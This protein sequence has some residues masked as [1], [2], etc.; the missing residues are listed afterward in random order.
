MLI[1]LTT[2]LVG[3]GLQ[4]PLVQATLGVTIVVLV[5]VYGREQHVRELI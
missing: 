1:E 5:S 4:P 2:V 3:L